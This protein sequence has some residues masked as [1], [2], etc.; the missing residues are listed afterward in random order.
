[1]GGAGRDRFVYQ[2]SQDRVDR[3]TDF[4][5]GKDKIVLSQLLDRLVPGNYRGRNAIGDEL[6][7]LVRSGSD[8]RIDAD[9]NGTSVPRGFKPLVLVEDTS[10]ASLKKLK[11][12]EF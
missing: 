9:L 2:N 8:T 11:N 10:L 6:I 12:F 4:E 1:M 3:I 7:R 5:I